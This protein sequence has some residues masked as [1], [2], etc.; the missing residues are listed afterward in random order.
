M[1]TPSPEEDIL[2]QIEQAERFILHIPELSNGNLAAVFRDKHW[3]SFTAL[4]AA[5]ENELH[6]RQ[7]EALPKPWTIEDEKE[8]IQ[9]SIDASPFNNG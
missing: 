8:M 1:D 2:Y 5:A 3:M 4:V 9:R 6:A 7:C